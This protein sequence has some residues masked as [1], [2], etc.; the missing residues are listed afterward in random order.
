MV[1]NY[2]AAEQNPAPNRALTGILGVDHHPR[3]NSYDLT[4]PYSALGLESLRQLR[5]HPEPRAPRPRL[6]R[7]E[8]LFR[9]AAVVGVHEITT[10]STEPDSV[11]NASPLLTSERVFVARAAGRSRDDIRGFSYDP[12][13]VTCNCASVCVMRP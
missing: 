13:Y 7:S 12:S 11:G 3:R 5:R 8:Q 6:S 4:G 10:F 2:V 1:A 9:V